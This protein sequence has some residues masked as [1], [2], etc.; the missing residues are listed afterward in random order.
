MTRVAVIGNAGGGK[1][2]LCRS[3]SESKQLP[4]FYVDLIQWQPNWKPTPVEEMQE[5]LNNPR[6]DLPPNC[7]MLGKTK[8]LLQTIAY[9]HEQLRPQLLDLINIYKA[10]VNTA[11]YH[12]RTPTEIKQFKQLQ[13]KK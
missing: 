9:V 1:S 6:E 10:D 8:Q 5:K 7:P 13:A 2:T 12:L 11:V 3:L 4:H